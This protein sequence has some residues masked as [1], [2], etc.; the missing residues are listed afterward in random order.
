MIT[1]RDKKPHECHYQDCGKSYCDMR[2]LRRHLENHHNSPPGGSTPASYMPKLMMYPGY[3]EESVKNQ[4]G[5]LPPSNSS[6]HGNRL[7][8]SDEPPRPSSAPLVAPP[9]PKRITRTRRS[10]SGEETHMQLDPNMLREHLKH[11]NTY[12]RR[13][14]E[15]SEEYIKPRDERMPPKVGLPPHLSAASTHL[16]K[17]ST[18][19]SHYEH[20]HS[21]YDHDPRMDERHH[22]HIDYEKRLAASRDAGKPPVSDRHK[23]YE[24]KHD[25]GVPGSYPPGLTPRISSAYPWSSH[26]NAPSRP[27]PA[28]G[29]MP[30]LLNIRNPFNLSPHGAYGSSPGSESA[31]D[32]SKLSKSEIEARHQAVN[33][34]FQM[35]ANGKHNLTPEQLYMY[36]GRLMSAHRANLPPTPTDPISIAVAAAKEPNDR[37]SFNVRDGLYGIHPTNA[38]WQPVGSPYI[39]LLYLYFNVSSKIHRYIVKARLTF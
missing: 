28:A 32:L 37:H 11:T 16:L 30:Y 23:E 33:T 36:Q 25:Y 5:E 26:Q 14:R 38:Q 17:Q 8:V 7:D 6:S 18:Q 2:S 1:H 3:N 9:E 29:T 27:S 39:C 10:S 15:T 13:E 12:A 35:L 19:M 22:H 24:G 20:K 34:Y 21:A 31:S 4:R